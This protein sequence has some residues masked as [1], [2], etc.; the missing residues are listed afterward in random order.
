LV[1]LRC[2]LVFF[3]SFPFQAWAHLQGI[4]ARYRHLKCLYKWSSS[5]KKMGRLLDNCLLKCGLLPGKCITTFE[6]SQTLGHIVWKF[7]IDCR[8]LTISVHDEKGIK[9]M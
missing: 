6:S 5:N 8:W 4:S 1:I 3:R 9:F 2:F 7:L